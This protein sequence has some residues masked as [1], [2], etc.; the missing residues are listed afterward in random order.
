MERNLWILGRPV[1]KVRRGSLPG[2]LWGG[3]FPFSHWALLCTVMTEEELEYWTDVSIQH[4]E[5]INIG[6]I[7]ELS[8]DEHNVISV[9]TTTSVS[10]TFHLQWSNH[11]KQYIGRTSLTD[12]QIMEAG[13]FPPPS[14]LFVLIYLLF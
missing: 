12:V 10:S 3:R 14:F 7:Y 5:H 13:I 11:I 4:T 6:M 9:T 8:R 1:R 2:A